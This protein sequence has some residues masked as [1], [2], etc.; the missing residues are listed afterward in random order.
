MAESNRKKYKELDVEKLN[1]VDKRGK[2]KMT[3]FNQENIPP[4]MMHGEDI[5]PGHRKRDPI[6]GIMFYNG[7][8]DECGGLIYGSEEDEDGNLYAGASLTF[9]LNRIRLYR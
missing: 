3:L 1:I 2:V 9:D 6:S 7:K 4:A 5:L 8:E